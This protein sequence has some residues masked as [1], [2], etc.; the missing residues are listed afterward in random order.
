MRKGQARRFL[1]RRNDF[2]NAFFQLNYTN[3]HLLYYIFYLAQQN[4]TLTVELTS[5]EMHNELNYI[6]EYR[7]R[8]TIMEFTATIN[9]VK[10]LLKDDDEQT[11]DYKVVYPVTTASYDFNNNKLMVELNNEIYKYLFDLERNYTRIDIDILKNITGTLVQENNVAIKGY[12]YIKSRFDFYDEQCLYLP[13][14]KNYLMI[15]FFPFVASER[16]VNAFLSKSGEREAIQIE[17]D[18][19]MPD[20]YPYLWAAFRKNYFTKAL[21]YINKNSELNVEYKMIRRSYKA[22]A[23]LLK[24]K[25]D[26]QYEDNKLNGRKFDEQ[27]EVFMKLAEQE[28]LT[29][30]R[31][32]ADS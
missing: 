4:N 27:E 25:C 32:P 23:V 28:F 26:E 13:I 30:I 9:C 12:E 29:Q 20:S 19:D 31:H 2:V 7:F 11:N 18:L 22:E 3:T 5:Q 15:R 8:E 10:F 1:T 6:K 17:L 21:K 24:I 16:V 14:K